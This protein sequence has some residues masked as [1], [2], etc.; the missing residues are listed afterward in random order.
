[1]ASHGIRRADEMDQVAETLR[2]LG[3][4]PLMATAT[5]T[6]QRGMGGIGKDPKVRSR[7]KEGRAAPLDAISAA[8]KE[9]RR[10]SPKN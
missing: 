10:V 4:D 9:R 8:E 5:A 7:L 6:R 1:M 2:E 3:I